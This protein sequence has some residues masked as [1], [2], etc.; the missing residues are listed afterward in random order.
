MQGTLKI[1]KGGPIKTKPGKERTAHATSSA[2]NNSQC[3]M[4]FAARHKNINIIATTDLE[5][6]K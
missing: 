1:Q 2:G 6:A 5:Q 3:V 4:N